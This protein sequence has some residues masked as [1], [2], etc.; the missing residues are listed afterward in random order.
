MNVRRITDLDL[1]DINCLISLCSTRIHT[2]NATLQKHSF[3]D[4]SG[5]IRA[6]KQLEVT[7]AKLKKLKERTRH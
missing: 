3:S 7:L 1:E 4:K 5:L 2:V 6:H